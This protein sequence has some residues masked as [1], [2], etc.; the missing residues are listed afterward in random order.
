MAMAQE[1]LKTISPED[2][3]KVKAIAKIV[4]PLRS[5]IFK[6][7]DEYGMSG[8][9]DLSIPSSRHSHRPMPEMPLF[10]ALLLP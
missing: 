3:A 1:Q 8:W 6:T 7:P 10:A 2:H 5:F 4:R 9:Y